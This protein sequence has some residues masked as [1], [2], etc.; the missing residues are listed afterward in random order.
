MSRAIVRAGLQAW[1]EGAVA[2]INTVYPAQPKIIPG[3]AF[4]FGQVGAT[5]GC[6][7]W[8]SIVSERETR[9]ALGGEHSGWKQVDYDVQIRLLY[10]HTGTLGTQVDGGIE[11]ADEF[12]AIVESLKTRIRADRTAAGTVWQWGEGQDDLSG[13]YGDAVLDD[14]VVEQWGYITVRVVE[15]IQ[16]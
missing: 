7:A 5:S 8:F 10:R 11:S 1:L 12:D 4:T 15:M 9:I 13:S 2:G 14:A 3:D 16:T 6:V